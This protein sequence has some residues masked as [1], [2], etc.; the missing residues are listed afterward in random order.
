LTSNILGHTKDIENIVDD[1]LYQKNLFP[2]AINSRT[3]FEGLTQIIKEIPNKPVASWF[4]GRLIPK[5]MQIFA[6]T[7]KITAI[8]NL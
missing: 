5:F 7:M 2:Q 6:E 3:F 4:D 8:M 1:Y